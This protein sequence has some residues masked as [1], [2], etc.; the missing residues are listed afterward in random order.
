MEQ[1]KKPAKTQKNVLQK[2]LMQSQGN[3]RVQNETEDNTNENM[4]SDSLEEG[5]IS[6]DEE[7][8][9]EIWQ[10][11][12]KKQVKVPSKSDVT[13]ALSKELNVKKTQKRKS[14]RLK[15]H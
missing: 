1:C 2:G 4:E 7:S 13:K 10:T 3:S 12:E 8:S 14:K 11:I 5:V 9:E 15:K 6:M